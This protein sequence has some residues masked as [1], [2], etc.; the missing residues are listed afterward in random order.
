MR[1]FQYLRARDKFPITEGWISFYFY[2]K[3]RLSETQRQEL[4]RAIRARQT[5]KKTRLYARLDRE[6]AVAVATGTV[7]GTATT[8]AATTSSSEPT[9]AEDFADVRSQQTDSPS[10]AEDIFQ[11]DYHTWENIDNLKDP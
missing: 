10:L 5:E 11:I 1:K 9:V 8:T 3:S 6:A 2:L 7:T 4:V